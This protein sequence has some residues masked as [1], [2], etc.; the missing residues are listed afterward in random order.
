MGVAA[1]VAIC[2]EQAPARR[3]RRPCARPA[4]LT[5]GQ[6][7]TRAH[8]TVQSSGTADCPM[9]GGAMDA[10]GLGARCVDCATRLS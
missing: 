2:E 1:T 9:C 4:G 10:R 5:I 8:D 3:D 7:L 6:L